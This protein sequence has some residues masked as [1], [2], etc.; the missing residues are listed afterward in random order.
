MKLIK[1]K[2]LKPGDTIGIVAPASPPAEEQAID[3]CKEAIERLGYKVVISP[4]VRKRLGFL[5]GTDEERVADLEFAFANPEIDAIFCLRGGWGSARLV[6]TLNL[7]T[8]K[9]N[10]KIFVGFSDIT[11]L[12]LVINKMVGLVTFHGPMCTSHLVKDDLP[13]YTSDCFWR[14][15]SEPA[16]FGSIIKEGQSTKTIVPGQVE[17]P[18]IGGNLS[19]I[20]TTLG[21]P[22]EIDTKGKIVFIEDV[23]EK[24]YR[25]DRMLTHLLNAGKLYDAA[26]IVCGGFTNCE[27][28]KKTEWTQQVE[29]VI[30]DRLAPL[31]I[32]LAIGFPFGHV[33]LTA[34]LPVG[35][36]ARLVANKEQADLIILAS[37]VS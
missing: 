6:R 9:N 5:A 19:I 16:P 15:L 24:P 8:I 33:D 20:V 2:R 34:T 4:N 7:E 17:G 26:G 18:L 27:P 1:P 11:M 12:H 36:P 14:I 35:V 25:I 22:Y 23:D 28:D 31:G 21:T 37:A 32:P 3:R 30:Q 29:D 13:A 10:P